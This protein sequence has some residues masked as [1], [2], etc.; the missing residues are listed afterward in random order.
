MHSMTTTDTQDQIA[1]RA[2]W[3]KIIEDYNASGQSQINYCKERDINKDHFAYYLGRWRRDNS[4]VASKVLF[5]PVEVVKLPPRGKWILN[6][7]PDLSIELPE[8]ASMQQLSE[9]II[10]LR[11]SLC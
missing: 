5:Q 2:A 9:L 1:K 4:K 10:S 6:I 7:A 8:V 11:K 3:Y